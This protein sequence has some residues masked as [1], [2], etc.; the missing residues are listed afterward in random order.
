[1]GSFEPD[2]LP[3]PL[4][5]IISRPFRSIVE[6]LLS[7]SHPTTTLCVTRERTLYAKKYVSCIISEDYLHICLIIVFVLL[8]I[9]NYSDKGYITEY[10]MSVMHNFKYH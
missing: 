6:V 7:N 8:F 2:K 4:K 5:T 1:M 3:L 10:A 9:L